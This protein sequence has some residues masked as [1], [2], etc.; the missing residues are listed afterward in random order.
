M[1]IAEDA[2]YA[3]PDAATDLAN[4]PYPLVILSPGFAISASGYGWLADHLA[5]HGFV[6]LAPEH[7]E[8]M[9]PEAGLW[10][11]AVKR[12]QEIQAVLPMWILQVQPG[13]TLA[14]LVDS[15]QGRG[16]SL[17]RRLHG[18]GGSRRAP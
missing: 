15:G 13:G 12:P 4:G 8:Q 10:Q 2:S 9:N 17:L 3:V 1:T 14:G 16:R 11:G 18:A 7:D 6:V 5:S